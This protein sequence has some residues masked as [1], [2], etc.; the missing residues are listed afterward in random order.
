MM[1]DTNKPSIAKNDFLWGSMSVWRGTLAYGRLGET[2]CRDGFVG[3]GLHVEG[4]VREETSD[5]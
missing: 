1:K 5:C 3:R 4:V 2:L